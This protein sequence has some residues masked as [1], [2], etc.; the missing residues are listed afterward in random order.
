M[1]SNRSLYHL[2]RL[3][4]FRTESRRKN[5]TIVQSMFFKQRK[6]YIINDDFNQRRCQRYLPCPTRK[7]SHRVG[8]QRNSSTAPH[9][10]PIYKE[11]TLKKHTNLSFLP[12]SN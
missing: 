4:P 11:P 7:R 5:D 1:I 9:S 6:D 3:C 12:L 10:I 8:S 2:Y